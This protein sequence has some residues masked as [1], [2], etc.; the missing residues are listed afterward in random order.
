[1]NIKQAVVFSILMENGE[2]ILDKAPDYIMEKVQAV[3]LAPEPTFQLDRANYAKY[4]QWLKRW[5]KAS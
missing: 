5:V 2:G 4:L 1:M 3:T